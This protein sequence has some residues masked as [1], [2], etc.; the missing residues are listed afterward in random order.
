MPLKTRG[1]PCPIQHPVE[2]PRALPGSP[3]FVTTL[4]HPRHRLPCPRKEHTHVTA[5]AQNE[6]NKSKSQSFIRQEYARVGTGSACPGVHKCIK[7]LRVALGW[8]VARAEGKVEIAR[9][10]EQALKSNMDWCPLTSPR[11]MGHRGMLRDQVR[12]KV[13]HIHLLS[14][15]AARSVNWSAM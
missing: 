1:D 4:H 2:W 8:R 3:R 11:N 5:G 6:D 14:L 12:P 15:V 9:G 7:Y 13:W 10:P